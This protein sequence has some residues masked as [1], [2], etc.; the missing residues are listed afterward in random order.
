L[1]IHAVLERFSSVNEDYGDLVIVE[2]A[3]F[4]IGV[5]VDFAPGE[6]ATLLELEE[7]LL[8]DFAEMTSFTGI[9][10]DLPG[11][12]HARQCSSFGAPFPRH[13]GT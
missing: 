9:N 11:L 10:Q 8:D 6:A 1:L 5:Y 12:C 4:S 3:D 13:G 7:A 2:A